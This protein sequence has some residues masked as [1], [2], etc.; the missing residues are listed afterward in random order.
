MRRNKMT[1][2]PGVVDLIKKATEEL[3]RK[4]KEAKELEAKHR[5]KII[6]NLEKEKK[7][8][9]QIEVEKK[10]IERMEDEYELLQKEKMEAN[11]AETKKSEIT[12]KDV[13]EGKVTA[14]EFI[15][16]GKEDREIAEM[17]RT[18]S[19][20]ELNDLSDAIREKNYEKVKHEDELFGLQSSI[21]AMSFFPAELLKKTFKGLEIFLDEQ[22]A[23]FASQFNTAKSM[24]SG[25]EHQLQ[26]IKHGVST[27]GVGFVWSSITKK[28][29]RR[30]IHDPCLPKEHIADLLEQLDDFG[31]D[32]I[33][34]V[35]FH[36]KGSF[37]PN[38]PITV[39]EEG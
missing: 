5:E 37:W 35:T 34:T 17:A 4:M 39:R 9:A 32:A 20:E 22:I 6:D 25:T 7:L 27:L 26:L 21:F 13:Q 14:R 11:L 28:A 29:A 31:E 16:Q 10:Q 12:K 3:D 24:K 33:V 38:D 23:P 8:K 15:A 2:N 18:K 1:E 19:L 30:L 36:H